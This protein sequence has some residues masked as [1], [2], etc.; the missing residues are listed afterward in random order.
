VFWYQ[1]ES[2]NSNTTLRSDYSAY[3]AAVFDAMRAKL[4]SATG[5]VD[6]VVIYA[7][8]AAYGCCD[9][10]ES[11]SAAAA[12]NLRSHDIA[13]RQRRF[14]QGAYLGTPHLL[15]NSGLS[16]GIAG[17]HMVVTHDLPRFDR[18]HLS[19][20]AQL[21]LAERVA[22]AYQE[23]VPGWDVDG[24]GPRPV[25]LPRPGATATRTFDRGGTHGRDPR[26]AAVRPHPPERR[27]AA[28]PRR[29][30]R[31]RLPGARA[32]LGRRR[33][34]STARVP[35]ALGRDRDADVRPRGHA[36]PHHRPQ[37][38]LR[39][40]HGLERRPQQIGRAHV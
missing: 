2:D 13:E 10:G 7:Q 40:L 1:G 32:R 9:G 30:G 36:S 20:E 34:G 3:T 11:S 39:V 22:L 4:A 23:H 35:V 19:A 6:P 17:A 8:L 5:A 21:I 29:E 27:G 31:P 37:R 25:P 33:H 38:L 26:P 14:E 24:T 28:D 12:E 16:N 18:I 15:P